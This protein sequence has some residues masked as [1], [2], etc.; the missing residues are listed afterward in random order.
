MECEF[1]ATLWLWE[2]RSTDKWTFVSLPTDLADEILD[3]AGPVSR[4]FGSVRVDVTIGNTHWR[5]SIFPASTAGTYVLPIKK[6]VRVTEGLDA[7]DAPRVRIT[8]VDL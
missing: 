7:G 1:E 5:T 6:A 3:V 4:G 8:L 2:A